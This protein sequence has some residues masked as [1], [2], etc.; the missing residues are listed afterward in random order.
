MGDQDS[1]GVTDRAVAQGLAQ[2]R[3]GIRVA[4]EAAAGASGQELVALV[5][6]EERLAGEGGGGLHVV[7]DGDE[8]RVRAEPVRIEGLVFEPER[9]D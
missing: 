8:E 6:E 5:D 2:R 9:D 1:P 7:V 3:G 4:D